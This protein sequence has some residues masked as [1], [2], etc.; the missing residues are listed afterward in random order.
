MKNV[1]PQMPLEAKERLQK[2]ERERNLKCLATWM[3]I[4]DVGTYFASDQNYFLLWLQLVSSAFDRLHKHEEERG[5]EGN[6]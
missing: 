6:A 3:T 4:N 2:R 5:K 1:L